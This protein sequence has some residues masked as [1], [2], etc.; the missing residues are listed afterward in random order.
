M[1][2]EKSQV[3]H[4][5]ENEF[6]V[7]EAGQWDQTAFLTKLPNRSFVVSSVTMPAGRTIRRPAGLI[8]DEV[9]RE[10][11]I[12]VDIPRPPTETGG[13]RAGRD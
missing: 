11:S 3:V 1:T 2:V 5:R 10:N 13:H 9:L 12:S 7:F 4:R 6:L 8:V